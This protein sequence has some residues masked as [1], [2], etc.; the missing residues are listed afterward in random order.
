MAVSADAPEDSARLHEKLGLGF[1]LLSD[2]QLEAIDAYGLRHEGGNPM[3][4][5]AIARPASFLIDEQG[6]ILWR[7]LTEDWRVRLDPDRVLE[8]L[9]RPTPPS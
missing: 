6:R 5:A 3:E 8:H 9:D 1:P 4:G 2:P 7:D